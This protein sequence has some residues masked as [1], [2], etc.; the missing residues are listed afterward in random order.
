[1]ILIV[2]DDEATRHSLK[3]LLECEGYETRAFASAEELIEQHR[4]SESDYLILDLHMPGI[5]GFELLEILRRDG[6]NLPVV[7]ITG[8][9]APQHRRRADQL[10]AL[11]LLEKPYAVNDLVKLF[12][13]ASGQGAGSAGCPCEAAGTTPRS[14]WN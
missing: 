4:P 13:R 6:N 12:Q 3:L 14:M 5:D 9:P 2:D 1:M 7:M 8:M 11:G 10:G